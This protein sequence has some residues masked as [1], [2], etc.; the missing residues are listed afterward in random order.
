QLLGERAIDREVARVQ[1]RDIVPVGV[2]RHVFRLD[3]VERHRRRVDDARAD[4]AVLQ[5][6]TRH[7]RSRIETDRAARDQVTP[8]HGDQVGRAR[9]GADEMHRHGARSVSASAQVTGPTTMRAAS[10]LAAGPPAASAAASAT[11]GTPVSSITRGEC[12]A[13]RAP[14]ARR[15]GSDTR[16]SG[17]PSA[18]AAWAIPGSLSFIAAVAITE[19]LVAARPACVQAASIAA[20]IAAA[21]TPFLHPTPPMIMASPKTIASRAV[22]AATPPCCRAAW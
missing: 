7:D 22:P 15:S 9:P 2:R 8:A 11:E 17:T 16:M 19:T 13:A 14:A 5:Q 21:D 6:R 20:V 18:A 10:R 1:S 12:V 4:R 3:L